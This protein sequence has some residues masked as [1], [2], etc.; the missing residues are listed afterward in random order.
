MI[1]SEGGNPEEIIQ[2]LIDRGA[3]FVV[4]HSGG[5]DSQAMFIKIRAL[6][7][8]EQIH[9]IHAHLPGVEWEGVME[10]IDDTC[11]GYSGYLSTKPL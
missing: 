1:E 10:H 11:Q 7:P 4:N 8:K 3:L 2:G 6:V 5:K 9:V